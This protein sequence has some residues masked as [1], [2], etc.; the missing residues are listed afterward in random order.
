MECFAGDALEMV[1]EG[2]NPISFAGLKL[3]ITSDES[4]EADLYPLSVMAGDDPPDHTLRIL[5]G[6]QRF[7]GIEG[8]RS[9][10]LAVLPL[11]LHHLDMGTV[12]EHDTAQIRGGIGGK[13]LPPELWR[14]ET[15]NS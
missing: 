12:T 2:I 8:F 5:H 15:T 3:A 4:R 10:G 9:L 14:R 11:C 1:R 13:Y 6:I 7:H